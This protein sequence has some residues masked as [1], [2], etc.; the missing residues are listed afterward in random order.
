MCVH[1]HHPTT[2]TVL[3]CI[4][5]KCQLALLQPQGQFCGR[6]YM[7]SIIV[8]SHVLDC[9]CENWSTEYP[10]WP[11]QHIIEPSQ[12]LQALNVAWNFS[13]TVLTWAALLHSAEQISLVSGFSWECCLLGLNT[14]QHMKGV[15]VV[16][17]PCLWICCWHQWNSQ[18]DWHIACEETQC[19]FPTFVC[20]LRDCWWLWHTNVAAA[21]AVGF[22][23]FLSL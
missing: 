15:N 1:K 9:V 13:F 6:A 14:T 17:Q 18:L 10:Y 7:H 22:H 23:G 2:S 20:G 3:V 8:F 12:S 4:G 5:D 21:F 11:Y 16:S 19:R